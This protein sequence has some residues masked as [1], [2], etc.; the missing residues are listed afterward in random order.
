MRRE[1]HEWLKDIDPIIVSLARES[2]ETVMLPSERI[3]FRVRTYSPGDRTQIRGGVFWLEVDDVR[4]EIQ[5]VRAFFG[6][7]SFDE[8]SARYENRSLVEILEWTSTTLEYLNLLPQGRRWYKH[9]SVWKTAI[10]N[11]LI[12][13]DRFIPYLNMPKQELN[14]GFVQHPKFGH[15]EDKFTQLDIN[16]AHLTGF[17]NVDINKWKPFQAAADYMYDARKAARGTPAERVLK[18]C[19]VVGPGMLAGFDSQWYM[20]TIAQGIYDQT[21]YKLQRQIKMVRRAGAEI[22]QVNTDGLIC[23]YLPT[24]E[25]EGLGDDLGDWRANHY[26]GITILDA[27]K[28]W[29]GDKTKHSGFR[30]NSITE[31]EV[32]KHLTIM[33]PIH[34][35]FPTF[36]IYTLSD[37]NHRVRID[38]FDAHVERRCKSCMNNAG[39]PGEVLH[40][41]VEGIM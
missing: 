40:D 18:F 21:R 35:E 16:S 10:D 11:N 13:D 27:N 31:A 1:V 28:Y 12:Q 33:K 6:N 29:L 39:H 25:I 41:L 14:Q 30:I 36:D 24:R 38:P 2:R 20:P 26:E 22:I 17:R 7:E 9:S 32:I 19:C 5:D 8:L 4:I 3:R 34:V 37:R 15:S 23:T